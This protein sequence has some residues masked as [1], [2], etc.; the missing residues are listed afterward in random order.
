MNNFWD[1]IFLIT[2]A[3]EDDSSNRHEEFEERAVS[4]ASRWVLVNS[5][6]SELIFS[7]TKMC[8][9]FTTVF[10][11]SHRSY[12]IVPECRKEDRVARRCLWE[13]LKNGGPALHHKGFVSLGSSDTQC[14]P[15]T[16]HKSTPKSDIVRSST[17]CATCDGW[18][19]SVKPGNTAART[20]DRGWR[21]R[22]RIVF[23]LEIVSRYFIPGA[24]YSMIVTIVWIN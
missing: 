6:K 4:V 11:P 24:W 19:Q 10:T 20:N 15:Q 22:F 9:R 1:V 16:P 23:H 13:E 8:A 12:W 5:F 18:N 21:E 7:G 17:S 14:V 2:R 3:G